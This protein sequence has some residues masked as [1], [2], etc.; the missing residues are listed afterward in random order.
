MAVIFKKESGCYDPKLKD[1]KYLI[2]A[3]S[4]LT[5][6]P[7]PTN[8]DLNGKIFV[9]NCEYLFTNL[10]D[11]YIKSYTDTS[12]TIFSL[13]SKTIKRKEPIA[14][15]IIYKPVINMKILDIV[16]VEVIEIP[17]NGEILFIREFNSKM[18]MDKYKKYLKPDFKPCPRVDM[19]KFIWDEL[20]YP[21][22]KEYIKRFEEM[23]TQ[24]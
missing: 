8:I 11:I 2:L 21:I 12:I 17:K 3:S 24:Y 22:K 10:E 5:I 13:E 19:A 6:G 14:S 20:P 18:E 16:D 1:G 15:L 4:D 9:K 7:T 23:A